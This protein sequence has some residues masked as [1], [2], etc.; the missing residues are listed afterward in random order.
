MP[1]LRRREFIT[2]LGGGK[3]TFINAI[4]AAMGDYH[5]TAPIETFTASSHDRHPTEL[6][7]LRGARLVTANETEEGRRWAESRI[8]AL[9]GGDP[10]PARFMRQD[11]FDYAPQFKLL[12]AGNHKPGLR[13]QQPQRFLRP[14]P[15]HPKG[16]LKGPPC[17]G[18]ALRL[19]CISSAPA[20]RSQPGSGRFRRYALSLNFQLR[21]ALS[22]LVRNHFRTKAL[23]E[24]VLRSD[25]FAWH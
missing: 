11:F 22:K 23:L 13:S 9:T 18:V 21:D 15:I 8:K 19:A 16:H 12:V 20:R 25:P 7:G 1:A 5:K 14:D 3:T 4:T 10:I 17:H 24:L 6:A 2:L